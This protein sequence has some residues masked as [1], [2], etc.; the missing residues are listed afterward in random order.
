MTAESRFKILIVA[1]I[2]AVTVA[3]HYGLI[4]NQIF[5]PSHWIHALHGRFCYI[6][7]VIAATWFGLR[8]G[9][10]AASAVSILV[11]PIILGGHLS[12]HNVAQEW[13]EIIFYFAIALLTG[14]LID[15]ELRIRRKQEKTQLQ[16]ERSNKLSMVGQ[17]AAS[18]AHEIKNPLASIKGALEIIG[19]EVT[20]PEDR[21]EFTETAV[22]EV[23]R[24]DGT[25]SEF[26]EFARPRQGRFEKL[27]LSGTL[28]TSLKQVE[29]H[30][31]KA[32]LQLVNRIKDDVHINGDREKIHQV[33]LN[34]LLNA[35]QASAAGSAIEIH[36]KN[37][38]AET[39]VM[40]IRDHGKGM[41]PEERARVFEPFYSTKP[42][43]TGLGLPIVKGIVESHRGEISLDS[44]PGHGTTVTV[45]FPVYGG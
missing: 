17:M 14:G 21:R 24:I 4:L 27:D 33:I 43:G 18:V 5:G 31:S 22:K 35:I 44:A 41:T 37:G 12:E 32:G 30:A 16:L 34:L 9:L 19:D 28:R 38:A 42:T 3:I 1:A 15:R 10:F 40:T 23:R 39:A 6:P 20:S 25:I 29:M 45:A 8:G 26:L 13:V 11:L 7:I 36:L 2:M